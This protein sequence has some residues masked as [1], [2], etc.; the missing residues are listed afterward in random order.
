VQV[1][2]PS[3]CDCNCSL[4]IG[5]RFTDNDCMKLCRPCSRWFKDHT[6][7]LQH[8]VRSN[9]HD[10]CE[11]CDREFVI[12]WQRTSTSPILAATTSII[13]KYATTVTLTAR[14]S[15]RERL[16]WT[17]SERTKTIT[18]VSRARGTLARIWNV[19]STRSML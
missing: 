15:L 17:I 9:A 1:F 5:H 2:S 10:Y 4:T 19:V 16:C 7:V 11:R 3:R 18:I 8:L 14:I 12:P 6:A 13:S